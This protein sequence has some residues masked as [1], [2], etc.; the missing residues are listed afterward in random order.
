M[1]CIGGAGVTREID[2]PTFVAM[3]TATVIGVAACVVAV[4]GIVGETGIR[5]AVLCMSASCVFV[6]CNDSAFSGG[7]SP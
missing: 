4:V 1:G 3:T 5:R 7:L 2:G 6:S